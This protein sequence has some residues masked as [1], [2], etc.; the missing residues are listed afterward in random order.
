MKTT[1]FKNEYQ[2]WRFQIVF[3]PIVAFSW[4]WSL[5]LFIR[6]RVGQTNE[7]MHNN[8][9]SWTLWTASTLLDRPPPL[10]NFQNFQYS[11]KNHPSHSKPHTMSCTRLLKYFALQHITKYL[12]N[13]L[14]G[15]VQGCEWLP[16]GCLSKSV[17]EINFTVIQIQV[18]LVP[19]NN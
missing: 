19:A 16:E 10:H 17:I 7:W 15:I 5:N 2:M 12:R 11:S 14:Q 9:K 3:G 8:E 1:K 18:L 4:A 13:L 6:R